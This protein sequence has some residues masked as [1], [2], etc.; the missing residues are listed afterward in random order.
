MNWQRIRIGCAIFAWLAILPPSGAAGVLAEQGGAV[1]RE[2]MRDP[3]AIFSGRSPGERAAGALTQS[4]PHMKPWQ[5]TERVL[6]PVLDR[7]GTAGPAAPGGLP[8]QVASAVG[9]AAAGGAPG[10]GGAPVPLP[11]PGLPGGSGGLIPPPAGGGGGSSGGGS[12]G[13]GSSGGNPPPPPPV[14]TPV[15]EPAT[16]VMMI[17]GVGVIGW[18][19]RRRRVTVNATAG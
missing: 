17:A 7:P 16:W 15:P 2:A 8:E 9:P 14:V 18:Q 11:I 4:K 5:P 13:G 3:A 12:S 10:A 6:S 1:L 19:L